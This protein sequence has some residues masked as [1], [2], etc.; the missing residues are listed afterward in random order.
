M[1][2][3][4]VSNKSDNNN[5]ADRPAINQPNATVNKSLLKSKK[6]WIPVAIVVGVVIVF[7]IGFSLGGKKD[8]KNSS[9]NS[10]FTFTNMEDCMNKLREDEGMSEQQ[11][12]DK[13]HEMEVAIKG[14]ER[15][16]EG[17]QANRQNK[18]TQIPKMK[19]IGINLD[20]YNP[21]TGRAGDVQ[22]VKFDTK[23]GGLDAIF[24]EYGRP[25]A[26]NNGMGAGRL[27]PQPTFVVAPG[28]EIQSLVDG[29][30]FD[31]PYIEHSKDYSVMVVGDNGV[32]NAV[33]FETEHMKDI[34]V[35]KGDKV[36]AGQI[37]GIA[38]DYDAKNLMGMSLIE[39]GVLIPGNPPKHDCTF[40]YLDY[41]V[42]DDI[43]AKLK[44]LEADWEQFIGDSNV[45]DEAKQSQ[46]PGCTTQDFIEG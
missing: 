21:A 37:L 43:L 38:S 13:C 1:E 45:F 36:K 18:K 4:N 7:G 6:L 33:T 20:K 40:K 26:A 22:F 14:P 11:A 15:P 2:E 30:V 41:S 16:G 12:S 39:I 34:R 9:K 3:N 35:K 28:T 24:N 23:A 17:S 25:A 10:S 8:G 29:V 44:Q 27:N 42:K 46:I 32:E 19:T 5:L 31:I